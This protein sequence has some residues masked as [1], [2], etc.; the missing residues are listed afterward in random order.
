M[1]YRRSTRTN[2]LNSVL[3]AFTG[4]SRRQFHIHSQSKRNDQGVY[5][6]REIRIPCEQWEPT[7]SVPEQLQ[8]QKSDTVCE[9]SRLAAKIVCI[10][11]LKNLY[12]A[13]SRAGPLWWRLR[14][15]S[16]MARNRSCSL[17]ALTRSTLKTI[18]CALV[19]SRSCAPISISNHRPPNLAAM[20][21]PFFACSD[22]KAWMRLYRIYS[23]SQKGPT[24]FYVETRQSSLDGKTQ[25]K[26]NEAAETHVL[27]IRV[28]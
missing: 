3:S 14:I 9:S 13:W 15:P 4:L 25:F 6:G 22:F 11:F 12:I 17:S 2:V 26:C 16:I 5:R 1:S 19:H 23:L 21:I 10:F 24:V 8:K 7:I 20:L 27:S 28:L 18:S